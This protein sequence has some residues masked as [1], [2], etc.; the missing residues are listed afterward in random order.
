MFLQYLKRGFRKNP[1]RSA[2]CKYK[3][4]RQKLTHDKLVQ[5]ACTH[6]NIL[7][8]IHTMY[9]SHKFI[10]LLIT[11][12]GFV[13]DGWDHPINVVPLLLLLVCFIFGGKPQGLLSVWVL[14]NAA[15]IHIWLDG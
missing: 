3:I 12:L 5:P 11:N 7:T 14:I 8:N 2:T 4:R 6:I 1:S 9:F 10:S 13:C 15:F